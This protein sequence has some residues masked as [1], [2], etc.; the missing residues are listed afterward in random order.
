[1]QRSRPLGPSCLSR[2]KGVQFN[3]DLLVGFTRPIITSLLRF[4]SKLRQETRGS[5]RATERGRGKACERFC[6]SIPLRMNASH[7]FALDFC[8]TFLLLMPSSFV[9]FLLFGCAKC[10]NAFP[11]PLSFRSRVIR[12][13]TPSRPLSLLS[14]LHILAASLPYVAHVPACLFIPSERDRECESETVDWNES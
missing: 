4:S 8:F 12:S 1:M 7:D 13:H 3:P 2:A 9:P 11:L 14:L 5:E 6:L 10:R